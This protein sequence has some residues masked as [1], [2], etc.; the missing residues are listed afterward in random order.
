M[1]AKV[2]PTSPLPGLSPG[3]SDMCLIAESAGIDYRA[4]I[5]EILAP[6]LRRL[7]AKRSGGRPA[8]AEKKTDRPS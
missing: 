4:L 1:P 5:G 2:E 7:E 3:W 6:A 8:P